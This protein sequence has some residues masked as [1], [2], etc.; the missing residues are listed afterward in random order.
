MAYKFEEQDGS[1]WI[2]GMFIAFL[3]ISIGFGISLYWFNEHTVDI[4][5]MK[6]E[7]IRR[8]YAEYLMTNKILHGENVIDKKWQWK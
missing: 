7:A 6:N 8:G 5:N 1:G 4:E 2:Y 3:I